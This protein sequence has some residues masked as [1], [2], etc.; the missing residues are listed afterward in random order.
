MDIEKLHNDIHTDLHLNPIS[1][2]HLPTPTAP[3]W[4]V[5]ESGLLHQYDWIY[6]PD[7][8]DLRLKILQSDMIISCPDIMDKT[9]PSSSFDVTMYGPTSAPSSSNSAA[10]ARLAKELRLPN[11]N[12]TDSSNSCPFRK[13][14]GIQFLWTLL[15]S[16]WTPMAIPLSSSSWTD[17]PSKAYSFPQLT[18]SLRSNWPIYSSSMYPLNTEFRP[19]SPV[20]GALSLSATSSAL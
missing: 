7:V 11:T 5:D 17:F 13:D 18:K 2:A 1:A 12:L 16:Y 3:N 4:T 15:S 9:K 14:R 6:A 20:I 19:M 10:H 8:A